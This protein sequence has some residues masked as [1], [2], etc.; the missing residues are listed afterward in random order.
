MPDQ[1]RHLGLSF[2]EV[3]RTT[4]LP[5]PAPAKR[6]LPSAGRVLRLL[7]GAALVA[8]GAVFLQDRF[9]A[10]EARQ[11]VL[12]GAIVTL[13]SPIEGVV[14]A[15]H[16][17]PL[18]EILQA[19]TA[20]GVVRNDRLDES[21]LGDLDRLRRIAEAEAAG[22]SRRL[23]QARA[24]LS[25]A[26]VN[27]AAYAAARQQMIGARLR[28]AESLHAAAAAR[29]AEAAAALSRAE[30]L[31]ASGVQALTT[32]EAARR[33]A[34]V[35]TADLRAA[36]DQRK[37]LAA[38]HA[39]VLAG[40]LASD[41]SHDRSASQL[42]EE[43]LRLLVGEI[44]ARHAEAVT[45][46]A[47]LAEQLA[48]ESARHELVREATLTAP[49]PVRLLRRLAQPGEHVA[50][51]QAVLLLADCAQQEAV[52]L[53]EPR[54]F[55]RLQQGRPVLFHPAGGEAPREG[56]IAALRAEPAAADGAGGRL[57]VVVALAAEESAGACDSGRLGRLTFP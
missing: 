45:R 56:R 49:A 46:A 26:A 57:E 50:A 6:R 17:P 8:T 10:L 13:R 12:D 30:R 4:P 32:L 24:E 52:A 40:V 35:A 18:G 36:A 14:E 23:D 37:A 41:T 7:L 15:L 53:V 42:S 43:R 29:E 27:A 2:A 3:P 11:A 21:R 25:Q 5:R 33:A 19:G 47:A 44:E 48:R 9:F 55:R 51:G 54:L 39:A 20:L 28:E 1:T 22:F 38:E 16:T 31:A 34:A